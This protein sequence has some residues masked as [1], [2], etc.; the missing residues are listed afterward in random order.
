MLRRASPSSMEES[1]KTLRYSLDK[2]VNI[3]MGVVFLLEREINFELT[4]E[5][6]R[7]NRRFEKSRFRVPVAIN[8]RGRGDATINETPIDNGAKEEEINKG[9]SEGADGEVRISVTSPI[10][11][12]S[13]SES[14]SCTTSASWSSMSKTAAIL[15]GS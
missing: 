5:I 4:G 3:G 8:H 10:S 13:S 12:T 2:R 9:R 15:R 6:E 7:R 14:S 11:I 1:W